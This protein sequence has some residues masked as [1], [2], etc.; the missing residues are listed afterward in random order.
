MGFLTDHLGLR[1]NMKT[2]SIFNSLHTACI[3]KKLNTT[4]VSNNKLWLNTTI[5]SND[6]ETMIRDYDI[7]VF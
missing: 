6:N 3:N 5:M 1:K 2:Q 4:K 7:G